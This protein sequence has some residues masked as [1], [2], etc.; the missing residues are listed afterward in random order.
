M[1]RIARIFTGSFKLATSDLANQFALPVK[2][3]TGSLVSRY[4]AKT[5]RKL[6]ELLIETHMN[7][8][9]DD[10][11]FEI[12]YGRGDAIKMCFEKVSPGKGMIFGVERSGYL[13]EFARKRF[14][15]EIAETSKIRIDSAIDLRNLPYP[16]D[17]FDHVFHVDLF[18]F[19]RQDHLI[20]INR[21]ILRVLKPGAEIV[22]AMQFSKLKKL[23]E[24]GILD[25]TQWDPMRYLTSLEAAEFENVGLSYHEDEEIGEYQIIRG[26]R[27]EK[28]ESDLDPEEM[29]KKLALDMKQERLAIAMLNNKKDTTGDLE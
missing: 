6:N 5:S 22:S 17:I 15:L 12:G 3:M 27:A 4:T 10:Y 26:R 16:T 9:K 24:N 8:G 20:D 13:D 23:T 19:L 1:D 7:V 21:E 2:S 25:R 18:Y 29:F 14:D 11:I 28:L